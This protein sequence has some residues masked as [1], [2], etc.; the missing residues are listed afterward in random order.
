MNITAGSDGALWFTNWH[1]SSIGP[2][3][4]NGA[5]SRFTDPSI[6]YP[7]RHR[8]GTRRRARLHELSAAGLDRANHLGRRRHKL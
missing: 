5:I 7:E 4:I 6:E 1:G 2:I 8:T 3:A